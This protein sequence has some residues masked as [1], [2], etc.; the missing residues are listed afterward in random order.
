MS[1]RKYRAVSAFTGEKLVEDSPEKL[2][3]RFFEVHRDLL[4][5]H[6]SHRGW[7]LN[8][9]GHSCCKLPRELARKACAICGKPLGSCMVPYYWWHSGEVQHMV[10]ADQ[11]REAEETKLSSPWLLEEAAKKAG[12][13]IADF[14]RLPG[15]ERE[16]LLREQ[17]Y[18]AS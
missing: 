1:A 11:R 3:L 18:A 6:N 12:L 2:R 8:E 7:C 13:V 5:A 15:Y 16:R 10:C 9:C 17:L 4:P 14:K